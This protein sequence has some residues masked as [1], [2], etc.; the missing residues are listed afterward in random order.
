MSDLIFENERHISDSRPNN[1]FQAFV[2]T[3]TRR[4][5]LDQAQFIKSSKHMQLP[6][7]SCLI[8][9]FFYTLKQM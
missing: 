6:H 1:L 9:F 8:I 4:D 7:F 3:A 5:A 2:F